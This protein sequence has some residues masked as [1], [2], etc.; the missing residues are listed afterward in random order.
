MYS[1]FLQIIIMLSVGTIIYIMA[2]ALP[3]V[4]ERVVPGTPAQ[5]MDK[6][7]KKVP[8]EKIDVFISGLAEKLLRKIKIY[9]LKIDNTVSA[10]L[11]K[12]KPAAGTA[13][14]N[15]FEAAR[16]AATEDTTETPKQN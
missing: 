4:G 15:I 12:F 16:T 2:R 8:F 7:V 6:L 11:S 9:V 13:K 10:H 3:R 14:T 5:Y 1:I